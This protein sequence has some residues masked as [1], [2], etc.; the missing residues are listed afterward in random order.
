MNNTV[1][2][3][4]RITKDLELKTTQSGV[5]YLRLNLAVNRN[6]KNA[7]GEYETDFINCTLYRQIAEST[8]E[9]C[10]KGDLVAVKGTIQTGSYEKEGKKVYTTDVVVEKITFL[11]TKK[12]KEPT[13]E[14]S[15]A[16]ITKAA[17]NEESDP[18]KDFGSEVQLT[19]DD[20]PF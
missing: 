13:P 5:E 16:E 15:Q 14:L 18:F 7:K 8:A 9:Y 6:Y 1:I 4:G 10:R 12:E 2:L 19:D 17:M 3:I 11:Q 20:L